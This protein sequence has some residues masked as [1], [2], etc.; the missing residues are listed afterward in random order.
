MTNYQEAYEKMSQ[1]GVV[2]LNANATITATLPGFAGY[3]TVIQTTH[4]QIQAA[5]VLQEA[6]KSGDS[7]AKKQL[8]ATLIAQAIDVS[9]RVVAYATNVNNN[10][11]LALVD[12]TESDLKKA[13]DDKLVSSCQ[14]IRDNANANV[15]ALATYGV[16][17]AILTTLQTSITNFNNAKPKNRVNA[18]DKGQATQSLETLFK[19]LSANWAKIDV[20]V[21]M[22]RTSQPNF[23][24]E[25]QKVRKVIV[26]GNGSLP[27][28][29]KATNAK[30]GTPEAN[31]K[32]TL[33]PAN[34]Q[35]KAAG[36]NGSITIV[37]KTA[38]GGGSNFK[39]L[40]DGPYILE[41]EK[42]GFKNVKLMVNVVNGEL[43]VVEIVMEK[44]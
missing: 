13:S 35:L 30:T 42:P 8:R 26:A 33:T 5:S 19:T 24:N 2:F 21:E 25:Y 20:L 29:V 16:T 11:L 39:S 28:Q 41:A 12:Y 3:F 34:G 4:T 18:T 23:Y 15:A 10:A 37:K 43:T 40:A 22:V 27:L 32:L 9:R 6:D 17:A 7:V 36:K 44:E 1:G 31:V 14:V 38:A